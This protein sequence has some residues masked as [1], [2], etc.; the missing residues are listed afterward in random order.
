MWLGQLR[1][2]NL[3]S[4]LL[5][6]ESRLVAVAFASGGRGVGSYAVGGWCGLS[7]ITLGC[8]QPRADGEGGE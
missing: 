4:S 7:L 1:P 6:A 5:L 2:V 3:R 8:R